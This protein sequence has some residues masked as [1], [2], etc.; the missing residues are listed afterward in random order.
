[1]INVSVKVKNDMMNQMEQQCDS[2]SSKVRCG[3]KPF[4]KNN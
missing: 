1:M 4:E 3:F 2:S